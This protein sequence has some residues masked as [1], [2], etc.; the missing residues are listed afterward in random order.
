MFGKI[1]PSLPS[2]TFH[3][4]LQLSALTPLHSC[5]KF[6]LDEF[7]NCLKCYLPLPMRVFLPVFAQCY[8]TQDW[9]VTNLNMS[10][11]G[12][13]AFLATVLARQGHMAGV[14]TLAITLRS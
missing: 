9:S 5:K 1:S 8:V 10:S 14:E 4:D 7:L 2:N 11:P 12:S 6:C 3:S 13:W